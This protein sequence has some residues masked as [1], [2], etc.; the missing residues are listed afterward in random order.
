MKQYFKRGLSDRYDGWRVRNV[1]AVYN[2]IP[3]IMRTRMDSQLSLIHILQPLLRAEKQ[4]CPD[5]ET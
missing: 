1:D 4:G 3:F 5:M 2:V